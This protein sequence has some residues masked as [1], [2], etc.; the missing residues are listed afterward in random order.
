MTPCVEEKILIAL[1]LG[2][3]NAPAQVHLTECVRCAARRD[4]ISRDLAQ[5]GR[6]L[7]M[8]PPHPAARPLAA[9]WR[10]PLPRRSGADST[11]RPLRSPHSPRSPQPQS[12]RSPRSPHSPWIGSLGWAGAAA[13][14]LLLAVIAGRTVGPLHSSTAD[15][16]QV[17]MESLAVTMLP[18]SAALF[19]SDDPTGSSIPGSTQD[20]EYAMAALEGD[21]PCPDVE[22]AVLGCQ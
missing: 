8:P 3:E 12:V 21:W 20:E 11:L 1:A 2:E 6:A 19:S 13:A 5:I 16:D 15:T 9:P 17:S 18:M 14:V 10:A 4:R 22:A 7:A